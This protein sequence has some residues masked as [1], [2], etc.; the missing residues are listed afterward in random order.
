MELTGFSLACQLCIEAGGLQLGGG[1]PI[2]RR[3]VIQ[4]L[5][6]QL[7]KERLGQQRW[8]EAIDDLAGRAEAAL[9]GGSISQPCRG[10]GAGSHDRSEREAAAAIHRRPCCRRPGSLGSGAPPS[11]FRSATP[12]RR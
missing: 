10:P 12:V 2:T 7:T 4:I 1:Q 11:G 9:D 8:G 6:H 3:F 5:A